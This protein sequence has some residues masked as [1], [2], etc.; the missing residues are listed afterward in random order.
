MFLR[1]VKVI[2]IVVGLGLFVNG[3]AD[4]L[5]GKYRIIKSYYTCTDFSMKQDKSCLGVDRYIIRNDSLFIECTGLTNRCGYFYNIIRKSDWY[6]IFTCGDKV[7]CLN[8]NELQVT[9][10]SPNRAD[11]RVEFL[12]RI[13]K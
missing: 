13:T 8:D 4:S 2:L 11:V 10:M 1:S 12:I 3:S 6:N 5:D 7:L 9:H